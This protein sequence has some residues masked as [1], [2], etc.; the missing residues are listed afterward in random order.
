[1]K[2]S[3]I[4][5]LVLVATITAACG[6]KEEEWEGGGTG[7]KV[8]LRS[9]TTAVYTKSEQPQ[10]SYH[11][12]RAYSLS[13]GS[14]KYSRRTGYYSDG[15]HYSSNVGHNSSKGSVS[16]GGFGHSSFHVSS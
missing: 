15:I 7:R 9:D 13:G 3:S 5:N 2:K 16:R 11:A 6:K 8:Y 14:G 12:F 1:M 10:H 4:I